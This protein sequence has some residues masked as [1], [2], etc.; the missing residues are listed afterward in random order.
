MK[1]NRLDLKKIAIV[2]KPHSR[3][4]ATTVLSLIE[5]LETHNIN[6]YLDS[7]L[8]TKIKAGTSFSIDRLPKDVD[9]F[10][11]LGGDGT[12]LSVVRAM[13]TNQIP[14]LGV[15]I[16]SLGFLTG[17]ALTNLHESLDQILNNNFNLSSRTTL[18]A[19]VK[20]QNRTLITEKVL[21]DVVITKGAIARIIEI[22]VEVDNQFVAVVQADGL[23]VSTPTGSTAYSLGAG[24]PIIAPNVDATILSPI[25]PHSLTYRPIVIPDHSNVTLTLRGNPGEVYVTFD[26][27]IS[28][29]LKHGDVVH[30]RKNKQTVKL[31]SLPEQNH[32]QVL[33]QKLRWAEQPRSR[34]PSSKSKS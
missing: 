19:S 27:Q 12:L 15:N 10:I 2:A 32:F 28:E 11:V 5:W 8:S 4:I 20:R 21:N 22:G 13:H 29:P 3:N 14:I 23:I 31:V 18:T 7:V 16:G 30:V 9:M 6:Y 26:G 25:C 17:V 24:G 33:R 1:N 34:K